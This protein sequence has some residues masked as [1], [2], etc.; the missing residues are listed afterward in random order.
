M[1]SDFNIDIAFKI[2]ILF[3]LFFVLFCLVFIIFIFLLFLGYFFIFY[4]NIF[5]F[6]GMSQHK[7]VY[8]VI[9]NFFVSCVHF[10]T[11]KEMQKSKLGFLSVSQPRNFS[12]SL[13]AIFVPFRFIFIWPV[14]VAYQ[15]IL[16]F[17]RNKEH[18][19]LIKTSVHNN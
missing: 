18:L 1:L 11:E 3:F 17:S 14:M 5:S 12:L 9:P 2:D 10:N 13:L 6:P 16:T 7:Y 4:M 19:F 8:L 15:Y